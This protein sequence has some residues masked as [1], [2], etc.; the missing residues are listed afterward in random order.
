MSVATITR[1]GEKFALVPLAEY[2]R[3]AAASEPVPPDY[4]PVNADGTSNA[5]EYARISMARTL[6]RNR[7]AAGLTQ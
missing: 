5:L 6:I 3:M 4:P 7:R 1:H 2:R